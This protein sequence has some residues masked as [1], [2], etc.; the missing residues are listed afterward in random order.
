MKTKSPPKQLSIFDWLK[1]LPLGM[2][3]CFNWYNFQIEHGITEEL[4]RT[5]RIYRLKSLLIDHEKLL[6][7]RALSTEKYF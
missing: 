5:S 2:Y 3:R 4:W 7:A 1:I 6:V